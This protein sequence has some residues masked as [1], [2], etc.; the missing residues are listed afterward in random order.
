[1]LREHLVAN[2]KDC[3]DDKNLSVD[4]LIETFC[5]FAQHNLDS[6]EGLKV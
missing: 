4:K 6:A 2:F 5:K 1:M 3:L